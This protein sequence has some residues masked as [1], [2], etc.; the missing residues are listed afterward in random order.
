MITQTIITE[1]EYNAHVAAGAN[2]TTLQASG[3]EETFILERCTESGWFHVIH[4]FRAY[5]G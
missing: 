4:L 5:F 1:S 2:Y 3:R